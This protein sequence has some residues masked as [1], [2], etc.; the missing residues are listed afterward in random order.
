MDKDR[1]SS[2]VMGTNHVCSVI[3]CTL[4]PKATRSAVGWCPCQ[5]SEQLNSPVELKCQV[6]P[7]SVCACGASW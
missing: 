6:P 4:L 3:P 2:L 7:G 1:V 5:C